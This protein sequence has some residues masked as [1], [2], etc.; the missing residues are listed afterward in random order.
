ADDPSLTA[1]PPGPRTATRVV[2]DSRAR[3]PLGSQLVRT[4]Q[5]FPTLIATTADESATAALRA[6]GCEVLRLP[7]GATGRPE[8]AD[9]LREL[10]R[11]RWTNLLVEGGGDVLGSFLDAR[12]IDETHVFVA[13]R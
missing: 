9:L 1:R 6:A 4:A 12:L 2:L 8:F 10:G 7:G 3:L 11:R 5:E 13:P